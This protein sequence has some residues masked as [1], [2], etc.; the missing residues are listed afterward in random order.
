MKDYSKASEYYAKYIEGS[1]ITIKK[2]KRYASILYLNK[3]YDKAINVAKNV[4]TV[5]PGNTIAFR[6]IAYSYL[7]LEENDK[8]KL[9]FQKLFDLHASDYLSSDYE[10]YADLLSKTGNDSLAIDY[11]LKVVEL[12][13]TRKDIYSKM[14]IL[15]FKNKNWN[16]VILSLEAKN[17]LT[18]QEYFDLGKAYYFTQ[19]YQKADSAFNL[20]SFKI[21]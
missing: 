1:E 6:I 11:L 15:Y 3:E 2:L 13:S 18:A 10:N 7:K 8:S 9:Y 5:E 17:D 14:S 20:L 16:G 19:N 12:D 4:I 21:T